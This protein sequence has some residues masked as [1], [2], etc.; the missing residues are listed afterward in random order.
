MEN[1]RS[2]LDALA[3]LSVCYFL[4]Y[5][6]ALLYEGYSKIFRPY[7]ILKCGEAFEMLS[8]NRCGIKGMNVILLRFVEV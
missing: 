1:L 4:R 7:H 3:D 8:L 6:K 5:S 2:N